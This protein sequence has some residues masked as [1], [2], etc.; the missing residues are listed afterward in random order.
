M[1]C[2]LCSCSAKSRAPWLT[3]VFLAGHGGESS[4]HK[5]EAAATTTALACRSTHVDVAA[6]GAAAAAP[7][8]GKPLSDGGGVLAGGCLLEFIEGGDG[9]VHVASEKQV[10]VQIFGWDSSQSYSYLRSII[11]I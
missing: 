3:G 8:T 7:E 6:A 9:D 2:Y 4:Q 1:T 5:A 11:A 10:S